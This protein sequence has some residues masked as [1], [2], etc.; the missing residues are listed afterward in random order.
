MNG[1]NNNMY[2]FIF[3]IARLLSEFQKS[4]LKETK[5]VP[6]KMFN[7]FNVFEFLVLWMS[8]KLYRFVQLSGMLFYDFDLKSQQISHIRDFIFFRIALQDRSFQQVIPGFLISH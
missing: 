8:F 4:G 6:S 5:T 3:I 2:I 1:I 7:N